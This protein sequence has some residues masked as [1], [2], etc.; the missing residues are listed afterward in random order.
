MK[1]RNKETGK[2]YEDWDDT[3]CDAK[4]LRCPIHTSYPELNDLFCGKIVEQHPE[5]ADL[6]GYESLDDNGVPVSQRPDTSNPNRVIAI[7]FDGTLFKTRWPEILEPNRDVI[8]RALKEQR[9]GAQLILWTCREG[10]LLDAALE[11]CEKEGL[12]FDAVNDSTEEWKRAW[13]TSPRKIG[14]TEYW[15]DRAVNPKEWKTCSEEKTAV[16]VDSGKQ[17]YFEEYTGETEPDPSTRRGILLQATRCVCEDREQDYGSPEHSLS[18]IGS[19]WAD[20]IKAKYGA[21]VPLTGAD[22][23]AMMVLFK[24]ARVATGHGKTDNWVDAA[25]YA[26]CGGELEGAVCDS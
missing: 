16:D 25:G 17:D 19:F 2:I 13:G 14:A 3:P 23:S 22:A 9:N 21:E 24:M 1:F 26:A 8:E 4:C 18:A 15:D 5:A 11:A 20:Y 7:D 10:D 12:H 6:L